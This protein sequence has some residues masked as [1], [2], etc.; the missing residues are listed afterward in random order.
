MTEWLQTCPGLICLR[1]HKS[2]GSSHK[3]ITT[4]GTR[5]QHEKPHSRTSPKPGTMRLLDSNS[6]LYKRASVQEVCASADLTRQQ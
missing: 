3:T 1:S 6:M 2:S 5:M 4:T